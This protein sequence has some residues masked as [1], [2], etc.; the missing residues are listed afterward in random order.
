M[1]H[2]S[3]LERVDKL[4]GRIAEY[5][6]KG[7]VLP[8]GM[9]WFALS[10]DVMTEYAFAKNYNQLDSKDFEEPEKLDRGYTAIS[11]FGAVLQHFPSLFTV[12]DALPDW[13]VARFDS[14]LKQLTDFQ[15][16][17]YPSIDLP[18]GQ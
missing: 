8:L 11:R 13:L 1:F 6:K 18:K 10:T 9:A 14:G 17:S 2:S 12:V 4:C 5:Q 7:T 15:K 3:I 16:V